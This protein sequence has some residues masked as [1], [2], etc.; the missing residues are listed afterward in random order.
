M[1]VTAAANFS[2]ASRSAWMLAP[3]PRSGACLLA[4]DYDSPW[5]EAIERYFADFMAFY[6]P[7]A[8]AQ[9]DW[10]QPLSFL[11]QELRAAMREA[12]LG[13]R[14]VDKLVRVTR[15]GG[16][17]E[18]VYIHLEIQ[19]QPQAGFAERM[20]VYHSRLFDRYRKPIASLALL[21]DDR[22]DWRPTNYA[23]EMF[24]CQIHMRFPVAK[25]LDWAGSEA[26]LEDS[27]NPF[28]LLTRA[29][30]ETRAT[31]KNPAARLAAKWALV[32]RLYQAGF[33]RQQIIDFFGLIDWMMRLPK[34]LDER[35]WSDLDRFEEEMK[36]R[37]VSSVERM[38]LERG[39]EAGLQQGMEQGMQQ[40]LRAGKIQVIKQLL[41]ARFGA[42][43]APAKAKLDAATEEEL[44]AWIEALLSAPSI[45]AV[46]DAS[47]H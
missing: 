5:K 47:R 29:H 8:H 36:M 41:A 18:W 31:R 24:G 23:H 16:S 10:A 14:V 4:D 3:E 11:D 39:M 7:Q 30:L 46:F 27:A 45:D 44:D 34:E 6:F 26:R 32:K 43:P 19:G 33:E 15:L 42:L 25:L 22:S 17:E 12:E 35:F 9:I 28:A 40:G 21:A 13:K 2:A 38:A 37:Y 20:F 1:N